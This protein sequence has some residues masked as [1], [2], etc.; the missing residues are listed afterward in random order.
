MPKNLAVEELVDYIRRSKRFGRNITACHV[1]DDQPGSFTDFP[2]YVDERLTEILKKRGI[3]NLYT[4]QW[5]SLKHIHDGRNPVVVTPTASGKTLCYNLPVLNRVLQHPETRALYLF[6]TKALSQ[7]QM[8]EIHSLITDLNLNIKTFTYDG[9]TPSDARSAIREHGHIVV[10]NPDMLHTAILPHHTKWQKLFSNLQFVVIDEMHTYRGVFGSHFANLM[11]RLK[12]VCRFYNSTPCF[13]LCSATI[14]NPKELACAL[15][16]EEVVL[17]DD[18]GAPTARKYI[19]L[20]NPPVVNRQLGIRVSCLNEARRLST[21]CLENELQTIVFTTSRLNVEVLT[22]YLKDRFDRKEIKSDR[23]SGY[24]GGYLPQLRRR[25]EQG[26][27]DHSILGV[28]ST[29]ALELGIDIGALDVSILAGYPGTIASIWQQSGRAGRR[30]EASLSILVARSNPLDQFMVSNPDYL[31]GQPP[32]HGRINPDNLLILLSHIKCAAF[33]LPL[34][35]SETFG[36]EDLVE[37]LS[38]LDEKGILHRVGNRFHWSAESYPANEISLRSVSNQN[39]VVI[40]NSGQE[41]QIIAEV[42]YSSAPFMI[43]ENAIY[44]LASRLYHVDQLDWER[45]KAYVREVSVDYY[46]DAMDYTN[47]KVLDEF[48]SAKRGCLIVEHGEVQ[49]VSKVVD[50]KKV[51]FYTLENVGY[52]EVNI[53][54]NQIHTTAYWFTVPLHVLRDLPY[55]RVELVDGLLGIGFLLNHVASIHLM[56]DLRDINHC[57]GDKSS[58]WFVKHVHGERKIYSVGEHREVDPDTVDAFD[59]TLF[60]YDNYPGG[61]GFSPKLFDLHDKLLAEAMTVLNQ[62]VCKEGC[63]SCIGP[64][65]EMGVLS[66]EVALALLHLIV[67]KI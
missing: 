23:I 61:V 36:K 10:S 31:L 47:V 58:R 37:V 1:I 50:F 67:E 53:P 38:Y 39:F 55:N 49:V 64:T 45:K 60:I 42:D 44:M 20:Y 16:E 46:T 19:I 66:K 2:E 3:A 7:D 14:A 22:K 15:I 21:L 62:C 5:E 59:P 9:D 17:V 8:H 12:R 51:R 41:P 30:Q 52:G 28:V 27:R 18:N 63:P 25:I 4:H 6:P 26:L 35:T 33:E 29:N 11:R 57:I 40:D 13:I 65:A 43:H 56:C 32:E 24:R 34:E 54:E 48:E